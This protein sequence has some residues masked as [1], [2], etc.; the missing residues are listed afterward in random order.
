MSEL[1]GREVALTE[2]EG[3]IVERFAEV[4]SMTAKVH[5]V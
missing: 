4:F 1:L 2:V 3:R 5:R